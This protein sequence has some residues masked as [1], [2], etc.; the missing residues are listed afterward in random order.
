MRAERPRVLV[1]AEG[2]RRTGFARV[3]RSLLPR[4]ADAYDLH[5]FSLDGAPEGV[6]RRWTTHPS[7]VFGD[8]HGRRQ[9]PPLARRLRPRLL[10]YVHDVYLYGMHADALD[11]LSPRPRVV[12]Y[13]PVDG[14][15]RR[16]ERLQP[17]VRADQ[18]VVF[19]RFARAEVERALGRVHRH[20]ADRAAVEVIPHGLDLDVF[21][22]VAASVDRVGI[23]AATGKATDLRRGGTEGDRLV[24]LNANRNTLR[25]RA[26]LT[27]EAFAAFSRDKPPGV[28]LLLHMGSRDQGVDVPN[29]S[30]RLGI[31]DRVF[32]T[33][34]CDSKPVIA[35]ADLN[36]VYNV[37]DIGLNTATA[38]AWGLVAFEHAATAAAQVMPDHGPLRELWGAAA[39]RVEPEVPCRAP[40]EMIDHR[41]VTAGA[42]AARLELLYRDVALRHEMATRARR[43][44]TDRQ[45]SWDAIAQRWAALLG[46]L[47][48]E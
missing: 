6:D 32:L 17:A 44:A 1:I 20:R 22:P 33:T 25:K 34:R 13:F 2:A 43:R 21:F 39:L 23:S 4:L 26:D 41:A 42:V 27:L 11:S 29:E 12:L 5:H 38:E 14:P 16:P 19:T 9:V 30:R 37:G 35:D 46:R 45:L 28:V 31:A 40:A 24:V 15:V 8:L 36:A 7:T 18:A 10:L 48:A 47:I 3:V